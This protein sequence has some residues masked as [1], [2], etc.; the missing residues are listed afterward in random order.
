ME[1][2]PEPSAD[3]QRAAQMAGR[4]QVLMD[5][6]DAVWTYFSALVSKGMEYGA[7]MQFA[8]AY[9][10]FMLAKDYERYQE[11]LKRQGPK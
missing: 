7:A 10:G 9:Q 11:W 1:D 5:L 6:A 8:A 3:D 4:D 2:Q